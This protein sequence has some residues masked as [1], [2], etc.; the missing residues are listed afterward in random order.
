LSAAGPGGGFGD[1]DVAG[2]GPIGS[3]WGVG[4]GQRARSIVYVVDRSG[5][6]VD[7]MEVIDLELKRSIGVL[8]QDQAFNVIFLRDN[9]PLAFQPRL[10]AADESGKRRAFTWINQNPP[11]GGSNLT[12][13]ARAAIRFAPDI[14][15]IV[16]DYALL[17][18]PVES[19]NVKELLQT[20]RT[21]RRARPMTINVILMG[22][23]E[24]PAGTAADLRRRLDSGGGGSP[25]QEAVLR[26]QLDVLDTIEAVQKMPAETGGTL[27]YL[28]G[29]AL[30]AEWKKSR[31]VP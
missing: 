13:A 7:W 21:A 1:R 15:F 25:Q 12:P 22:P 31:G 20:V 6:F 8:Q 26:E 5:S 30:M 27:Q 23:F 16:T 14:L 28:N 4:S 9:A 18:S 19:T 24:R 10:I 11:S 29:D 2:G 3:L 17:S